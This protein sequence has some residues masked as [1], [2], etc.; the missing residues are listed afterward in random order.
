LPSRTIATAARQAKTRQM[1]WSDLDLNLWVVPPAKIKMRKE[2]KQ[3]LSAAALDV[4]TRVK[5]LDR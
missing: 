4:L 1:T 2:H 5:A 3:H